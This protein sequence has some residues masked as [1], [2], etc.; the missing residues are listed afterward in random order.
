M[1]EVIDVID[2]QIHIYVA[3]ICPF[4]FL[5]I[6]DVCGIFC[7]FESAR[8]FCCN[9]AKYFGI[10]VE[11]WKEIYIRMAEFDLTRINC[12]FLDRHLTFPLLEF[13]CGKEV[14]FLTIM[15]EMFCF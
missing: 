12:Q 9:I 7:K 5:P 14:R 15:Q 13:L 6:G 8:Y 1:L 10:C 4:L 11:K 2:A 3:Y